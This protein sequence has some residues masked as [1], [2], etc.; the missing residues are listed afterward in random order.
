MPA[1]HH[2]PQ[3]GVH[4]HGIAAE[5]E[6]G[7]GAC[8]VDADPGEH[9]EA[10]DRLRSA[11]LDDQSRRGV[12][13]LGTPVVSEPRPSSQDVGERR[14]SQLGD[15]GERR[16]EVP[17]VRYH[18]GHLGLLQHHFGDEDPVRIRGVPPGEITAIASVPTEQRLVAIGFERPH[19][20]LAQGTVVGGGVVV[21]VVGVVVVGGGSKTNT[22]MLI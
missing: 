9:L 11:V 10:F 20:I 22:V 14:S 12:K 17:V 2:P 13:S 1:A 16:E 5:C 6:T 18:A 4:G 8:R 7:N 19:A 15:V 3:V 21:V